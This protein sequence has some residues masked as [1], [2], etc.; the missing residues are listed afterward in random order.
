MANVQ[1]TIR[2]EYSDIRARHRPASIAETQDLAR[3]VMRALL[4]AR[5]PRDRQ[6]LT[7]HPCLQRGNPCFQLL[8]LVFRDRPNHPVRVS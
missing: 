1:V 8:Y 6:G 4:T 5:R 3:G 2:R 7:R